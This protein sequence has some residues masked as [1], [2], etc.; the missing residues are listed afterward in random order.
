MRQIS[1]RESSL[2]EYRVCKISLWLDMKCV[3]QI[4]NILQKEKKTS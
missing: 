3:S 1:K 2:C 4:E